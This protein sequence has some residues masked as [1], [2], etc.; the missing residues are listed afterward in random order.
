MHLKSSNQD[1]LWYKH[2]EDKN[3]SVAVDNMNSVANAQDG[4]IQQMLWQEQQ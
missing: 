3:Y 1:G 2:L 4:A